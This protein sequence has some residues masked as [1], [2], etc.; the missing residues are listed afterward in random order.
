MDQDTQHTV[1]RRHVREPDAQHTAVRRHV[2]DPDTQ[3]PTVKRYIRL[4]PIRNMTKQSLLKCSTESTILN[5]KLK[6]PGI[7]KS[8]TTAYLPRR[9][10]E[11]Q[12]GTVVPLKRRTTRARMRNTNRSVSMSE[13]GSSGGAKV[14]VLSKFGYMQV[15]SSTGAMKSDVIQQ[16]Q[17]GARRSTCRGWRLLKRLWRCGIVQ[18]LVK[19]SI[20][21]SVLQKSSAVRDVFSHMIDFW[22]FIWM[23][24]FIMHVRQ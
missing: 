2:R 22:S 17:P 24:R 5:Q 9:L 12:H 23:Y 3:H 15:R 21:S 4:P 18:R 6:L 11:Y 8:S 14:R 10:F 1:S 20:V 16:L 19:K 7:T 13:K